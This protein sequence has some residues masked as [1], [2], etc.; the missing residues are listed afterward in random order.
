MEDAK[1]E[2]LHIIINTIDVKNIMY[3]FA[4]KTST[5]YFGLLQCPKI[6]AFGVFVF[7]LLTL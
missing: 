1:R 5:L 6:L 4:K 7:V 3:M 2:V